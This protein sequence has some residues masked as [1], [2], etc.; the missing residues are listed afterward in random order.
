MKA[1]P[2]SLE[3]IIHL[4][5]A[6]AM[7]VAIDRIVAALR[8]GDQQ[9][10]DAWDNLL[11]AMEEPLGSAHDA[12]IL[13]EKR[14]SQAD[15]SNRRSQVEPRERTLLDISPNPARLDPKGEFA[16][17]M[18]AYAALAEKRL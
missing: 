15:A 8:C 4:L 12:R 16:T 18:L 7:Q 17:R 14:G 13:A 5:G 10:I 3:K 11:Q 6:G 2:P 9:S 1:L